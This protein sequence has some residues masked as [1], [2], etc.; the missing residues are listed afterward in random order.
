MKPLGLISTSLWLC[1]TFPRGGS[2]WSTFLSPL[3]E[4]P[5]WELV[6]RLDITHL[7]CS[8]PW[9][10]Y[11]SKCLILIFYFFYCVS[12]LNHPFLLQST[13]AS[14]NDFVSRAARQD[15]LY[16]AAG[17]TVCVSYT[18]CSAYTFVSYWVLNSGALHMVC[19]LSNYSLSS[20]TGFPYE[21]L[22]CCICYDVTL[23]NNNALRNGFWREQ[24]TIDHGWKIIG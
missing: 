18:I 20:Q 22:L 11:F 1:W 8:V 15:V 16:P 24:T 14:L 21:N 19:F 9:R 10:S 6:T 13:S 17:D 2:T 23:L 12:N 5:P 7:W 4:N 3:K